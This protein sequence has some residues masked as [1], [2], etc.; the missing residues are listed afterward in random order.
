MNIEYIDD[1]ECPECRGKLMMEE[2]RTV[3]KD[4]LQEGKLKCIGCKSEYEIKKVFPDLYS[5][6]IMLIL[7]VLNGT[8]IPKLN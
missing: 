6:G 4:L 3:S 1:M 2:I 7:L 5:M 8:Y